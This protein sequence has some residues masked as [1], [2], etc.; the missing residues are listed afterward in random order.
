MLIEIVLRLNSVALYGEGSYGVV[1]PW[2]PSC[3]P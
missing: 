1:S 3:R 2:G